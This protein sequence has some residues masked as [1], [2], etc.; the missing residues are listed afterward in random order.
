M[1]ENKPDYTW[2]QINDCVVIWDE[3]KGNMTVTN[4][5]EKVLK[6]IGKKIPLWGKT[7]IYRDSELEYNQVLI[8]KYGDFQ[9]YETPAKRLALKKVVNAILSDN[10]D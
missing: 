1:M 10:K 2:R 8:N 3:N 7:I 6:E 5:I 4:G 9:S